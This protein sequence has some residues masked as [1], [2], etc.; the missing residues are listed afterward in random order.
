MTI[1]QISSG[2]GIFSIDAPASASNRT[3]TLPDAT[4][5]LVGTDATQ[6]LTNKTLTSPTVNSPTISG[7]TATFAAMPTITNATSMIRLSTTNGYGSTNTLVRRWTTT[8]TNQGSDI[9]YADSAANGGSFTINTNG[10]YAITYVDQFNAAGGA[11][12]TLNQVNQTAN[13]SCLCSTNTSSANSLSAASWVGYLVAG[14]VIRATGSAPSG[15]NTAYT[16]FTIARV[17]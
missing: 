3:I 10:V 15:T 4:T 2:G 17:A 13:S 7:G 16:A 1:A 14:A 8:V 11:I 5:T 12:I 6:T 9:T